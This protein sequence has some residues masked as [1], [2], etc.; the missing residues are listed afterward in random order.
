[1]PLRNEDYSD[2]EVLLAMQRVADADGLILAEDVAKDLG[3]GQEGKR[4]PAG[5][6]TARLS[7]MTT[8]KATCAPDC[9]RHFGYIQRLD[10]RTLG[11]KASDP[12][13]FIMTDQVRTISKLR[14]G[15][16]LGAISHKTRAEV[17]ARLRIHL[18][19]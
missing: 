11:L 17:E 18:A 1:M 2:R 3:I 9:N 7:W 5:T 16:R 12:P 14:L 4:T 8:H 19:L 13:R 6:V 15:Q 10:P